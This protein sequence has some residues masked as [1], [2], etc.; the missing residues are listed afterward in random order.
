MMFE[1]IK[2][3]VIFGEMLLAWHYCRERDVCKVI[4]CCSLAIMVAGR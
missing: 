1:V 3:I 4:F 2:A